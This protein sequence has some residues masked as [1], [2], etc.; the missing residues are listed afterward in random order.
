LLIVAIAMRTNLSLYFLLTLLSC[1]LTSFAQAV[2]RPLPD[3]AKVGELS[4]T[5]NRQLLIDDKPRNLSAGAQVR[6]PQN[7][8]IQPQVL[9]AHLLTR[10]AG[11][12]LPILYTENNIGQIHR[13]WILTREEAE[14]HPVKV[15]QPVAPP[16]PD[17]IARPSS[18]MQP[19][20]ITRPAN[21]SE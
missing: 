20:R 16:A 8:I 6:T 9:S 5:R 4:V 7:T 11:Q 3:N 10:Y 2:E 15:K 14:Q 18:T 17:R 19:G 1:L 12:E 21:A 13:V